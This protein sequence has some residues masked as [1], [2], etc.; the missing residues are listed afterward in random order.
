[1][2]K[3]KKISME[4]S[5]FDLVVIGTGPVESMVACSATL[6][7]KSVL[8]IDSLD[9]YGRHGASVDF[10]GLFGSERGTKPDVTHLNGGLDENCVNAEF[11][12]MALKNCRLPTDLTK[13]I[14]SSE[15]NEVEL[16]KK[17]T[18]MGPKQHPSTV[19]YLMERTKAARSGDIEDPTKVHP[20]FW[21][22][23][24]HNRPTLARAFYHNRSFSLDFSPKVMPG[25]G[26]MVDSLVK[27]DAAKYLEFVPI[28][29]IIYLEADKKTMH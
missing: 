20:S 16:E 17:V 15:I 21:G 14:E 18:R 9:F 19:D 25:S 1:M 8:Q 28:E 23:V 22:Y 24:Q 10:K 11:E 2:K 7:G 27:S 6:N 13:V 5:Y 26:S 3:L 12:S 29:S 4:T